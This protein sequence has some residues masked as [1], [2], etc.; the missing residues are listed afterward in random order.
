MNCKKSL[1]G[2]IALCAATLTLAAHGAVGANPQTWFFADGAV[3]TDSQIASFDTQGLYFN[4]HS[5]ANAGG[6]IRG[7]I[8]PSSPGFVT[9]TGIPSAGNTF[10]TLLSGDQEI[11]ANASQASGYGA[12]VFDPVAK[13]L[14]GVL[15]TSGIAGTVAHIHNGLP[16]VSGPVA[17]PLTG[18]PTVWTVPA[19][20]VLT[21]AQIADLAAG[22]YYFNVHTTAAPGGEIRGQL[23][24]QLRF[25]ALSGANEVPAVATAASGTGVLAYNPAT[26]QISGFVQTSGI[27]GSAAHIHEAAAGANGGVI[28][29]LAESPAGSGRWVVP[30]GSTL[31]A[32]QTASFNTNGLYFNVHSVANPRGEICGQILAATLKTGNA[33]LDGTQEVPAVATAAGGTGIMV[34]NSITRLVSGNVSTTLINGTQ[35]HVHEGA[36]GVNGP[37]TI[38]LTLA[39]PPSTLPSPLAVST[40]SLADGAAGSTYSQSLIATGG[41]APYAWAVA[42][43]ALPAGLS[44]GADGVISGA[45]AAAGSASFTVSVT[46]SASP[47]AMATVALTLNVAAAPAATV[48]Y[49]AQVQPIFTA[50]CAG[51]CHGPGRIAPDLTAGNSYASLVQGA[52]PTV[53][54]GSSATSRLYLRVS[55]ATAG[56][57]M[58]LVGPPLSVADQTL[59]RNWIDQGAVNN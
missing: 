54:P 38:P 40:T 21:D 6:E 10:A 4:V 23:T 56:L 22:A 43:G 47:A 13:T 35:A 28:V 16:G 1:C 3:L 14:S 57:Q 37:V 45:P 55:G 19:G 15:V 42:T 58:P 49:S 26:G 31:T 27:A 24:Q 29:P 51:A 52:V 59:V 17:I 30:A 11:P 12:V 18:G 20:T 44:L 9:D 36:A 53:I 34:L 50:R 41:A 48:S 7:Q 46:D 5:A 32:A 2:L 33:S 39:P 25:A 8:I